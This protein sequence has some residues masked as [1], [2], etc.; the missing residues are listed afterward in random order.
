MGWSRELAHGTLNLR[1]A[2]AWKPLPALLAAPFARAG[3][4][5]PA[6]WD[7]VA[8]ASGFFAIVAAFR[9]AR[10]YG[11]IAGAAAAVTVL[12]IDGLF[13]LSAIGFSEGVLLALVLAGTEAH[14]RGRHR[15]ALA[16]GLL[17]ALLRPE[18]WP[19]L[20]AYA[21]LAWRRDL[22]ARRWIAAALLAVPALW[23][24]PQLLATGHPFA[25]GRLATH[26]MGA[27]AIRREGTPALVVLRR[28]EDLLP[29]PVLI[30]AGVTLIFA[31]RIRERRIVSWGVAGVAWV[32]IVAVM[33]Q[34][35]F[36]GLARFLVPAAGVVAL[37]AAIGATRLAT[38]PR[39]R[40]MRIT[41]ALLA[42]G[43]V[44]LPAAAT[45]S[46]DIADGIVSARHA[47]LL[48]HDLRH[49]LSQAGGPRRLR[50]CGTV[51]TGAYG[52]P[53]L[54]WYL[55]VPVRTDRRI[56]RRSLA[57]VTPNRLAAPGSRHPWYKLPL[58]AHAGGWRLFGSCP[59]R[60]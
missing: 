28:A 19:F 54:E 16:C 10:R 20:F 57:T 51:T 60:G 38:L 46:D 32:T 41:G 52:V 23:F 17:A 5:G 43:L 27:H 39:R 11:V 12:A 8:R 50:T 55:D 56:G 36:P 21:V 45:A 42:A 31:V 13:F 7:L 35:G 1:G 15:P 58:L 24:V 44:G 9:L 14:L 49:A 3:L 30:L 25:A 6:V 59:R 53:V 47:D 37:L 33:A 4:L 34:L 26:S 22:V 40:W 18:T 48:Y 29:D 2:T